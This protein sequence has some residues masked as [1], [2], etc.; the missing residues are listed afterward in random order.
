VTRGDVDL[1]ALLVGAYPP[2]NVVAVGK[3]SIGHDFEVC[4]GESASKRA[5]IAV[6]SIIQ[7]G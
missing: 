2:L 6:E 4:Y 5:V 7:S 3:H 1:S